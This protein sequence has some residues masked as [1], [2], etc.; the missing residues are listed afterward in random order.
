MSADPVYLF[1]FYATGEFHGNSDI[2]IVIVA[3]GA[4]TKKFIAK[5]VTK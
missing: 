1:G 2:D 3:P 5:P 4:L